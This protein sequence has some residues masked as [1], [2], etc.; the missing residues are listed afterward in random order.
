MSAILDASVLVSALS[1]SDVHHPTARALFEGLPLDTPFVV[2]ALFRVEVIAAFARRGE[3]DLFL[4]AVDALVRGPRFHGAPLDAPILDLAT[5]I[6]QR[7][8]L[9]A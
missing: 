5:A 2:P 9:R 3:S 7:A 8:R 4:D 1:P 6:G